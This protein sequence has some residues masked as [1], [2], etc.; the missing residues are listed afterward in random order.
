MSLPV[1]FPV[2][3]PTTP[4][5][6][7]VVE[8]ISARGGGVFADSAWYAALA[9]HCGSERV[10]IEPRTRFSAEDLDVSRLTELAAAVPG[11]Y[12]AEAIDASLFAAVR[13]RVS[14]NLFFPG[15]LDNPLAFERSGIGVCA[16]DRGGPVAAATSAFVCEESI[17][18]QVNVRSEH[19]RRGLAT[20]VSA[21]LMLVALDR[22]LRPEW[23]TAS[24]KS[25]A[26]ACK[27]GYVPVHDYDCL[28]VRGA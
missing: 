12:R 13:D 22:G 16:L 6:V 24:E 17:E 27:L 25:H 21:A 28:V 8:R 14:S 26:L 9:A 10:A 7:A 11:G 19:Q 5:G 1:V 2:G 20:V 23:D 18:I 3:D 15:V 4:A